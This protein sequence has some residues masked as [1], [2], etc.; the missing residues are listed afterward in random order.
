MIYLVEN[1]A[2][3][4]CKIGYSKDPLKRLS[5]LRTNTADRL[6]LIAEINGEQSDERDLHA[7]FFS[8]RMRGEWF[9]CCAEIYNHFGLKF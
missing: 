5:G 3:G 6:E 4:T 2:T 7:R 1:A 9:K 8:Y